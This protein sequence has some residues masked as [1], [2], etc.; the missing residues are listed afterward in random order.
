MLGQEQLLASALQSGTFALLFVSLFL[1]TIMDFRRREALY[2]QDA[3]RVAAQMA[4]L[5]RQLDHQAH[6]NDAM[7]AALG[8]FAIAMQEMSTNVQH[9]TEM[10]QHIAEIIERLSIIEGKRDER[11]IVHSASRR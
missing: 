1:W 3:D 2:R 8:R 11:E 9:T 4:E 10:I 5:T 6:I 7:S